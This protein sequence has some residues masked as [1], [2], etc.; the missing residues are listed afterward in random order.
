MRHFFNVII[1]AL[2]T[3]NLFA[4]NV[5]IGTDTPHSNAILDINGVNKGLLI[6]RG[7]AAFR[8]SLNS[9]TAK[10]LLMVDT[11][12]NSLWM[13]NGNGFASGWQEI[14]NSKIGF[15]AYATAGQTMSPSYSQI[16][17]LLEQFDDG[18][19]FL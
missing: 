13:H 18:N 14:A 9:N 7:D 4:Q 12:T 17:F 6:P 11:L 15:F 19:N 8:G 3:G 1:T 16:T 2:I 10:G 5:E